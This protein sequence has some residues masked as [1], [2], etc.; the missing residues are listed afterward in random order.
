ME[1]DWQALGERLR[2]ARERTGRSQRE[3]EELSGIPQS[4]LHRVERGT[5]TRL[6]LSAVDALAQ[7]LGVRLDHLMYGSPVRGRVLVAARAESAGAGEASEVYDRAV[8]LLELDEI[9]DEL[10]GSDLRQQVRTLDIAVPRTGTRAKRGAALA[11]A[12]RQ[13]LQAGVAPIV[14]L[15]VVMQD[16]TG[17]DV[18]TAP[19]GS[20]S[21][22]CV[23][24]P[25]RDT[26]IVLV[27][28][29]H[30]PERQRF[31]HAH[32]LGHLLW[33]DGSHVDETDGRRTPEE[34][35]CDE[36]ARHFLIPI[37]GVEAWMARHHAPGTG[38]AVPERTVA[39]LARY[40]Q[41]SATVAA[42]QL[43]KLGFDAELVKGRSGR[44]LAYKYGW[45]P[46][47]VQDLDQVSRPRAPQ[48]LQE[49]ATIAYQRGLLGIGAL[50]RLEGR[51]EAEVAAA[52]SE[53][54]PSSRR[55]GSLDEELAALLAVSDPDR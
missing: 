4:T 51:S 2:A 34:Q 21:G 41:V 13:H 18:G 48:R 38:D 20:V 9:L 36:F 46:Q 5:K 27:N 40:F 12:V 24:D 6:D 47:Y 55:E 45:G 23:R 11:A 31:T 15:A 49:R 8:E 42:I 33:G 7:A 29:A 22:A 28:S 44:G 1:I 25:A 32:E 39:S 54:V 19:L 50:A 17:V 37:E 3:L 52:L 16:L 26:S 30:V 35:R 43:Q 14:D 53:V 10:V